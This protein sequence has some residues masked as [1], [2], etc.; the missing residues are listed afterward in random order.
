MRAFHVVGVD[1][2]ER[3]AVDFR[4]RGKDDVAV[5]LVRISLLG[6][7][8]NIDMTI[9]DAG[10]FVIQDTLEFLVAGTMRYI[11]IHL[12][13]VLHML[14][15]INEIKAIDLGISTF[16]VQIDMIG[17]AD[18]AAIKGDKPERCRQ[19]GMAE[20]WLLI[21]RFPGSYIVIKVSRRPFP[22]R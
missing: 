6:I 20:P 10:S 18:I 13:E 19:E 3:L 2:Q 1:L 22:F 12:Q 7:R 21:D 15:L 4:R 16:A 5:V 11:M 9:E 17:I 8:C 14:F